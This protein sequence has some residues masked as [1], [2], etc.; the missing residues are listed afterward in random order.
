MKSAFFPPDT[1]LRILLV[2]RG[3][4]SDLDLDIATVAT[5]QLILSS[6]TFQQRTGLSGA[7]EGM[8]IN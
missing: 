2:V 4:V 6:S 1:R 8:E 3:A 7:N 5:R